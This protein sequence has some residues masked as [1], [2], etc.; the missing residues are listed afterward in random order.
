MQF[1]S[2]PPSE[3]VAQRVPYA[4]ASPQQMAQALRFAQKELQEK[5]PAASWVRWLTAFHTV[6][7]DLWVEQQTVSLDKRGLTRMVRRLTEYLE[8]CDMEHLIHRPDAPYIAQQLVN[9]QDEAIQALPELE[10]NPTACGPAVYRLVTGLARGSSV[11][12]E[13]YRATGPHERPDGADDPEL[14]RTAVHGRLQALRKA[15]G[16]PR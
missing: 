1:T 11:A 14:A 4:R 8:M 12:Q 6:R 3:A 16:V 15:R 10:A 5:L 7:P 2:S 13:V 9:F